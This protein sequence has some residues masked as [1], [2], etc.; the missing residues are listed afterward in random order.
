MH[1]ANSQTYCRQIFSVSLS[2]WI[3]MSMIVGQEKETG[4]PEFIKA[5][6][7]SEVLTGLGDKDVSSYFERNRIL[8]RAIDDRGIGFELNQSTRLTITKAGG[9]ELLFVAIERAQPQRADDI[10][11]LRAEYARLARQSFSDLDRNIENQRNVILRLRELVDKLGDPELFQEVAYRK[12]VR[13]LKERL[14]R[15]E[16]DLSRLIAKRR[17]Q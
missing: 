16:E 3:L 4:I 8:S 1:P 13:S 14:T 15:H 17:S 12:M 2:V 11:R 9:S 6:S 7:F 10:A 5:V